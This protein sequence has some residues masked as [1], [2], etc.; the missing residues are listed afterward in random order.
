MATVG[1]CPEPGQIMT[2]ANGNLYCQGA[3]WEA[4]AIEDYV[5][6]ILLSAPAVEEL[7]Q[8]FVAGFSLPMITYLVSW[9]YGS[10]IRFVQR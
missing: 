1:L 10:V 5:I 6:G 4:L 3:D 8:A 9:G 7:Q 2:R